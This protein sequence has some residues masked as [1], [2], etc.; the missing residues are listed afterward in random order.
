[1]ITTHTLDPGIKTSPLIITFHPEKYSPPDEGS[2][3]YGG[4]LPTVNLQLLSA[5]N[6]SKIQRI[7]ASI[8][9]LIHT[10]P[11]YVTYLPGGGG[12]KGQ[13]PPPPKSGQFR[14]L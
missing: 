2:K 13:S 11:A 1:M 6:P 8:Q 12:G 14:I 7:I 3:G 5:L 9:D 10:E 4:Q